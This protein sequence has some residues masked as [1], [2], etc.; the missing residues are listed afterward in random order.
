MGGI[1]AAGDLVARMQITRGMR[2]TQAKQ[3]VAEKI[4]VTPDDL[5]D[6]TVM[7]DVRKELGLGSIME[8]GEVVS[9]NDPIALEAKFN[10][11]ELLGIP[12]NC[13]ERFRGIVNR[14]G[15]VQL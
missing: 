12:V 11:A 1:R 5:S 14:R 15:G 7:L 4:G 6:T 3:Y 9:V 2:L 10:I 8:A 13:V